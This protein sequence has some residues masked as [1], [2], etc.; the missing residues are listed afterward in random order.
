MLQIGSTMCKQS[1]PY[2]R[3][4]RRIEIGYN[5]AS[6][7]QPVVPMQHLN[8]ARITPYARKGARI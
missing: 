2:L 1:V 3:P 7:T 8:G 4:S 6:P 5:S